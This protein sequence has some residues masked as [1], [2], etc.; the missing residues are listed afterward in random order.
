MKLKIFTIVVIAATILSS[1][2]KE[3]SD[4]RTPAMSLASPISSTGDTLSFY[5]TDEAGIYRM[6]TI[7]VGDTVQFAVATTGYYN[8]IV[9]FYLTC[10]DSA[11]IIVLPSVDKLDAVFSPRSDYEAG[12]FLLD[13]KGTDLIFPFKYVAVKPSKDT[14]IKLEVV[15]DA[16]FGNSGMMGATNR[17]AISILTPIISVE[18]P[19]EEPEIEVPIVED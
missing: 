15:S 12:I 1:C 6:D 10:S 14:K 11:A 2:L 4:N 19:I 9:A 18:E 3:G 13:G 16:D 17:S 7:S 8:N 5:V